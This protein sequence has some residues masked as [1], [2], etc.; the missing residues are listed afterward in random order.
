MDTVLVLVTL[1]SLGLAAAMGAIVL[2]LVRDERRRSDARVEA[3]IEAS[4]AASEAAPEPA[5]VTA[6]PIVRAP[7]AKPAA[8]EAA[9]AHPP[10]RPS[11]ERVLEDFEI[12]PAVAANVGEIFAEP[13]RSSP[14]GR[15]VAVI[16]SLAAI[17]LA[18]FAL[19]SLDRDVPPARAVA[20]A[21]DRATPAA[22]P[23]ELVALRHT[24][25]N[26]TLTISGLVRNPRAGMP[27]TRVAVT[28]VALASD[29]K[30]VASGRAPLDFTSL[31]P[32]DESPFV[33][34]VPA[35]STVARYRVGFR[36]EDGSVVAHVDRRP[37]DVSRAG[38]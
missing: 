1:I 22:A 3:L 33:V 12:R 37:A 6:R 28:A 30:L 26:G 11:R 24:Q 8:A 2:K 16:G 36:S 13:V 7:V 4:A 29:G 23:L 9:A 34:T 25:D 17:G 27:L 18:A 15:R 32:G 31:A 38:L 14:W 21:A 35:R 5:I 19:L 10:R 20:N